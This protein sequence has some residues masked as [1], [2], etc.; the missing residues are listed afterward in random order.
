MLFGNTKGRTAK[1][2]VYD[3]CPCIT[4]RYTLLGLDG[5][6]ALIEALAARGYD[7][8]GPVER[9]GAII[10]DHIAGVADL[11]AG[12]ID[13]QEAGSYRLE[14]SRRR[15]LFG[16]AVGPQSWKRYLHRPVET[17]FRVRRMGDELTFEPPHEP[18]TRTAFIGVR[19]CELAAIAI[20]DRVFQGGTTSTPNTPPAA[21]SLPGGGEL[22]PTRRD[23]LLHLADTGPRA[24]G[25]YDIVLTELLD[26]RHEFLAEPGTDAGAALLAYLPTA[27]GHRADCQASEA[28]AQRPPPISTEDARQRP[29]R[30]PGGPPRAPAMG[31]CGRTLPGLRQLHAGLPDLLLHHDRGPQ[32]LSMLHLHRFNF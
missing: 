4:P 10:F 22:R 8:I 24:H 5:L 23:L 16:Y 12:R 19:A 20:Q 6:Q 18:P 7:V 14:D 29:E 2:L 1:G 28:V 11:P 27:P 3:C 30:D 21:R 32:R 15:A 13:R 25:G 26:G 31:R 17:L 9:D